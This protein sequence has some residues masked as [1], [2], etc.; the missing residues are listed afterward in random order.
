MRSNAKRA[1][2][3]ALTLSLTIWAPAAAKAPFDDGATDGH[4]HGGTTG[5][6]PGSDDN[7]TL[8]G[9]LTVAD[10]A[11]G[12]IGDVAVWGEYAY[13]ASY[14]Q[15]TCAGPERVADGGVYVVD[16]SDPAA[17]VEVGFIRSHQDT[18]V[19]EGV[20]VLGI[21]TA[22]FSGDLL[23][24][25][26]ES[27]GKNSKGGFSLFDVT[28]PLKPRKIIE[29]YGDFTVGGAR[30]RP[31]NANE[32]HS[33]FAWQDGE[34][35]YLVIV[36]DLESLDV[37]IYDITNPKKPRMIGEYDLNEMFPQITQPGSGVLG[38]FPGS[39]L[40]DMVVKEIN[41]TQTMLLSYWDGGYV[42]L[43]VD[44]PANPLYIADSD[45]TVPDPELLLQTGEEREP[46]GNAHQA[47][48]TLDNEYIIAADEDFTS[49][50]TE[51]TTDDGDATDGGQGSD[52]PQIAVGDSIAGTA[53]YVGRACTGDDAVPAPPA[54]DGYI[55]VTSRGSC[56]F[57]EKVANIEAA[58]G[59]D[60]VVVVNREGAC[61]AFGM[62]VEGGIPTISIDRETGFALFDV[63][64]F[65]LD[66]CLAGSDTLEGSLI[67]GLN[68]GDEGDEVTITA[69][70]DGWGYVH[71]FDNNAGKLVELDTYAIDEAM[72]PAYASGFGDLSVHEVATSHVDPNLAYLAYYSGGFRVI[73][74]VNDQI[75]EVGHYIAEGGNNFWGVEVFEHDGRE[76]V[77]ASDRDTGLWIFEYTPS[78]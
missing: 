74:I 13:L 12:K 10:A 4:Q 5:H 8:V 17:P 1:W 28:N 76:L 48:F 19:A 15:G 24:Q 38:S 62:A 11:E 42:V 3:L 58:G 41:G 23:V 14:A 69:F 78:P 73:D 53:V 2:G 75:V 50:G 33:A 31:H 47:E 52:T 7:V 77:A 26:N 40:H 51:V 57:S 64:G 63:D 9:Q 56:T 6:L 71:L 21:D 18:F 29:N 32:I 45:F 30:V 44:D 61:G 20:Q 43:D 65:D 16:I 70:F 67:P 37:D 36:D 22:S 27:C 60:A 68:P 34:R 25:N 54:D 59:Y 39:F 46:E 66:A 49:A 35:A 72:D 55:A